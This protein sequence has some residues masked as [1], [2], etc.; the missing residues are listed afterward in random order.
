MPVNAFVS[1]V[2]ISA[3][4][5]DD[6]GVTNLTAACL[7]IHADFSQNFENVFKGEILSNEQRT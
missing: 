6:I 7:Q 2:R 5:G 4:F 3:N 1:K